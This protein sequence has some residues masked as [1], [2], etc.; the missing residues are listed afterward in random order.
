M[1]GDAPTPVVELFDVGQVAVLVEDPRQLGHLLVEAHLAQ[2]GLRPGQAPTAAVLE[3]LC[4][5]VAVGPAEIAEQLGGEVP[6]ALGEQHLRTGRELVGVRRPAPA[7]GV[8]AMGHEVVLAQA[9]ELLAH[10]GDGDPQLLGQV[11]GA[12]RA[13]T[14]QGQQDGASSTGHGSQRRLDGHSRRRRLDGHSRRR[15]LDG[16][17]RRR[18]L[19]GH[20]RRRRLDG[21]S[22]VGAHGRIRFTSPNS[23]HRYLS[24]RA[25]A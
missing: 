5:L 19:D 17:S 14:L 12:H 3:E 21:H 25:A 1:L 9:E 22:V 7:L 11:L 6:V 8:A 20:G 13:G 10:G 24:D 2:A 23:C 16:H 15:R 4:H 18:R